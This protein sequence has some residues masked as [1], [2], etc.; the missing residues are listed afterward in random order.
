[1]GQLGNSSL[2]ASYSPLAVPGLSD[3]TYISAGFDFA[4]AVTGGQIQC[5]GDGVSCQLGD[6]LCSSTGMPVTVTYGNGATVTGASAVAAGVL[7]TCAIVRGGAYC[8][9][10]T[11]LGSA[12]D[13]LREW[14]SPT[15]VT[16]LSN[17]VTSLAVGLDSACAVV[18]DA[19]QC[20]G[21]NGFGA[22]GNGGALDDFVATPVP[23][24]P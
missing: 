6:G 22:L 11:T 21:F 12:V 20:W 9:G 7:T 8:W 1:M 10:L 16:G 18:D 17:G 14:P 5:W 13:P 15:P 24:F 3:A 19:I 4:C 2:M 23:G